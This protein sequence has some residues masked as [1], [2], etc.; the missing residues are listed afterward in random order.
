MGEDLQVGIWEQSLVVSEWI[1]WVW[2]WKR[3]LAVSGEVGY[4]LWI[5]QNQL[6]IW[7]EV[8]L[9]DK[10]LLATVGIVYITELTLDSWEA[11]YT[12]ELTWDFSE[13]RY[14][15]N[16][17]L[18]LSNWMR[19]QNFPSGKIIKWLWINNWTI[20]SIDSLMKLFMF[21]WFNVIDNNQERKLLKIIE[22]NEIEERNEKLRELLINDRE[23]LN[24]AG[25]V[26]KGN[27]EWDFSN[28]AWNKE[29]ANIK[30]SWRRLVMFPCTKIIREAWIIF[31]CCSSIL[32]LIKMFIYLWFTVSDSNSHLRKEWFRR[33][34]GRRVIM[35]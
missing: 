8:L 3:V 4:I 21:L 28:I 9:W 24:K 17:K 5:N 16:N 32:D 13:A 18:R 27:L 30:I 35:M 15:N 29:R 10:E 23:E 31:S 34:R 25:I 26:Y 19:L 2:A 6:K 7:R 11:R 1:W 33:G 20:A 14:I 22:I 12:T